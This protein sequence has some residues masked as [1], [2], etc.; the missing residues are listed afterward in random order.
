MHATNGNN[1][2]AKKK[3]KVMSNWLRQSRLKVNESKLRYVNFTESPPPPP[4][5]IILNNIIVKSASFMNVLGLCFDLKLSWVKHIANTI[6]T[7][8]NLTDL[9]ILS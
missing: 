1:S 2:N 7:S 6:S 9:K 5:E 4:V 8:C 3:L